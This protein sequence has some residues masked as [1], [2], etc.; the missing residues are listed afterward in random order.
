MVHRAAKWVRRQEGS[1]DPGEDG[2][3]ARSRGRRGGISSEDSLPT[4]PPATLTGLQ[5]LGAPAFLCVSST[6]CGANGLSKQDVVTGGKPA[7]AGTVSIA[8]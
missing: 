2:G 8:R 4:A 3:R 7:Q 6:D 1:D 5:D